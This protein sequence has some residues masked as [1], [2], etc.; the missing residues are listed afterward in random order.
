MNK[1][2]PLNQSYICPI[3]ADGTHATVYTIGNPIG[4]EESVTKGIVS[5]VRVGDDGTKI[6]QTDSAVSPGNSGGPLI[7]KDGEVIGVVTFKIRGGENINFAM[8]INYAR[9]LP[10]FETLMSLD[11]LSR[12]LG[13]QDA[14]LFNDAKASEQRESLSGAWLSLTSNTRRQLRQEGD[15]LYGMYELENSNGTYS[16]TTRSNFQPQY[17][18]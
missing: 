11:E 10:G 5:S 8:P 15:F 9:A 16:G 18:I 1:N 4:L 17:L 6:I 3:G 14:S 7:N 13:K 12:E 2:S